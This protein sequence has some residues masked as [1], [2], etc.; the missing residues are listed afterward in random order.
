MNVAVGQETGNILN[1]NQSYG[2]H[3]ISSSSLKCLDNCT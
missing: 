2:S 1:S 3:R